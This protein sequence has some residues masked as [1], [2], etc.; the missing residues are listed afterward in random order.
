MSRS[1]WLPESVPSSAV[2]A[3]DPTP[4]GLPSAHQHKR[5]TEAETTSVPSM[6]CTLILPVT[7]LVKCKLGRALGHQEL[8]EQGLDHLPHSV[9]AAD[10]ERVHTATAAGRRLPG[11]RAS[12]RRSAEFHLHFNEASVNPI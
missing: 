3:R 11:V 7:A 1:P 6:A 2:T 12:L 4:A 5:Q 10:V 9:R 8:F